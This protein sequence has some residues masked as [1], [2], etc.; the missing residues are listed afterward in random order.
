MA[1]KAKGSVSAV[2][3]IHSQLILPKRDVSLPIL[4]E[5]SNDLWARVNRIC[6]HYMPQRLKPNVWYL[7]GDNGQ[8]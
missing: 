2:P 7:K 6:D 5:G 1:R 8:K 4:P 3:G